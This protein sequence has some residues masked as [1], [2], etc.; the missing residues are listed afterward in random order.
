MSRA[1]RFARASVVGALLALSGL[2]C[3]EKGATP[4]TVAPVQAAPATAVAENPTGDRR[5]TAPSNC[6][7]PELKDAYARLDEVEADRRLIGEARDIAKRVLTREPNCA[8]GYAVLARCEYKEGARG[9]GTY[10]QKFMSRAFKFA[11]HAVKLDPK[12]FEARCAAAWIAVFDGD[13]DLARVHLDEIAPERLGE[14]AVLAVRMELAERE[15]DEPGAMKI[16]RVIIASPNK[17]GRARWSAY[18]YLADIYGESNMLDD[19]HATHRAQIAEFPRSEFAHG[20][21]ATFLLRIG[22]IDRA[23]EEAERAVALVPYPRAVYVLVSAYASKA[24]QLWGQRRFEEAARYVE[25]IARIRGGESPETYA[26]VGQF[27]ERAAGELARPE[28]RA[29]ARE[30]YEAALRLDPEYQPALTGIERLD[31]R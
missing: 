1:V 19:A 25:K 23:I 14:P 15:G 30:A 29:K 18:A 17:G 16:A 21:Y 26:A 22:E 12:L 28:M 8:G 27:Y 11:N 6:F 9:D 2:G 24:D 7:P 3:G 10:D 13:F 31:K 4:V 5:V 20:N